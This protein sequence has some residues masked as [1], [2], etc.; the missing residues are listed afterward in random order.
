MD[1]W[2]FVRDLMESNSPFDLV[3]NFNQTFAINGKL[4][5][6]N[7]I[8]AQEKFFVARLGADCGGG[9]GSGDNGGLEEGFHTDISVCLK[10]N[11]FGYERSMSVKYTDVNFFYCF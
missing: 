3:V 11:S 2:G 5:R 1:N 7:G 6:N 8:C 10:P 4:T 9:E